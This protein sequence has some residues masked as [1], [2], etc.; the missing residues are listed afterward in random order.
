[1]N[2]RGA[3]GGSMTYARPDW[4]STVAKLKKTLTTAPPPRPPPPKHPLFTKDVLSTTSFG[5]GHIVGAAGL[6]GGLFVL[7]RYLVQRGQAQA[8][9]FRQASAAKPSAPP[10]PPIP[11]TP[12][13]D[14]DKVAQAPN[15]R[16]Q[17]GA[18]RP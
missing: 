10:G 8:E 11:P 5:P 2:A 3:S 1:M 6:I 13:S 12:R 18:K 7:T 9:E 17:Y 4:P 16:G 14:E 15:A